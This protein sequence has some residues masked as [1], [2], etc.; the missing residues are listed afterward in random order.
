MYRTTATERVISG[1]VAGAAATIGLQGVRKV[2]HEKLPDA[3]PPMRQEPGAFMV[4][5]AKAALPT[6]VQAKIPKRAESLASRMLALG[7]GTTFGAL[8]SLVRPRGGN[9]LRDGALLGVASWAVGYL[10]WLPATGLMPPVTR[11]R[12][13]QVVVPVAEHIVFGVAAVGAYAL[14]TRALARRDD[15]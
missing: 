8:Y 7:Y 4:E 5:R 12:P 11:Q 9:V 3:K 13:K 14:L 10:G 15:A 2:T 6:P 1:A